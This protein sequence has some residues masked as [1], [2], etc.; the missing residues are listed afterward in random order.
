MRTTLLFILSLTLCKA[1]AQPSVRKEWQTRL[2]MAADGDTIDLP[3]GVFVLESSLSMEGKKGIVVR[4]R[5]MDRTVIGFKG[6]QSGAEGIRITNSSDVTVQDL[7]V[8]DTKGDAI[9]AMNVDGIV[10]RRVRTEWSGRP[11]KDNGAYGLYPVACQRVLIEG[12]VVRGASDAGIYVGQ[13]SR[14]VVRDNL[15]YENVAGIEIENST[16]ADVYGNE[17]RDNTGGIL[18]FDL[19]DLPVKQGGRCRVYSNRVHDNNTPNFAPKGNIVGKVP[20]GTGILLLAA[21][22]VEVFRN[23]IHR[24]RTLGTGIISYHMTENPISDTAYY[25]FPTGISVYDNVYSRDRRR[26]PMKGRFGKLYRF[27]LRYGKD[28]PDI[29]FDGIP[30]EKLAKSHAGYPAEKRICIRSNGNARVAD[31][32]AAGD[33]RNRSMDPKPF[34]CSR[35]EVPAVKPW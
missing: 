6:Q 33:F 5:G 11:D 4:G 3:E 12:C 9:K 14:I 19:P 31:L 22:D 10:F 1:W 17:A 8:R 30:D 21:R 29:V 32:D 26:A 28:L 34:D 16:D 24:N 20:M 27:K 18:V 7:T 13:S 35:P 15:A 23:E 2:I 25:P